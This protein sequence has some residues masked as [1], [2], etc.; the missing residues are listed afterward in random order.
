[1]VVLADSYRLSVFEV[2]ATNF[3]ALLIS[4]SIVCHNLVL[5]I[6]P[7]FNCHYSAW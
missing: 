7:S 6:N 4:Y 1:M 5:D 2:R 3:S